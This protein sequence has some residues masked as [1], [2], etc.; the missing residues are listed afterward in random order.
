MTALWV[1]QIDLDLYINMNEFNLVCISR[2]LRVRN[3]GIETVRFLIRDVVT[4]CD[5][6]DQSS[7]SNS[8]VVSFSIEQD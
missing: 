3:N 4:L 1:P 7:V 2:D 8:P 5:L 6:S